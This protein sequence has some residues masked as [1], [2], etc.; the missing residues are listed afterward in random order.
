[1]NA[2]V[3]Q[4]VSA[5]YLYRMRLIHLYISRIQYDLWHLLCVQHIFIELIRRETEKLT[6]KAICTQG[7]NV[8]AKMRLDQVFLTRAMSS[9]TSLFSSTLLL[10]RL[11]R[12]C[13]NLILAHSIFRCSLCCRNIY[14]HLVVRPR[15]VCMAPRGQGQLQGSQ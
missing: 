5:W 1:M 9:N 12:V 6:E 3:A 11:S 13:S 10:T 7:L 8:T 14:C 4:S 2:P 15:N